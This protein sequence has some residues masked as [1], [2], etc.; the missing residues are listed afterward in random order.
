MA[1]TGWLAEARFLGG[2]YVRLI[3]IQVRATMQYKASFLMQTAGSFGFLL[4]EFA[5]I[6]VLFSASLIWPDG[7]SP[8]S[9]CSTVLPRRRS[10]SRSCSVGR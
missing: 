8:R 9:R 5:V 6:V 2:L 3:G 4:L 1:Q 7:R 10:A